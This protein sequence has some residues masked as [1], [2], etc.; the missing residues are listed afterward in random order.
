MPPAQV[1]SQAYIDLTQQ[2]TLTPLIKDQDNN[3]M[4]WEQF[5]QQFQAT[6]EWTNLS[7][8]LA[9]S[10][11]AVG[12][13]N[14]TGSLKFHS[15]EVGSIYNL[16]FVVRFTDPINGIGFLSGFFDIEITAE[17]SPFVLF[18]VSFSLVIDAYTPE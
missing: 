17:V 5:S 7:S 14:S 1:E 2:V 6:I 3:E 18:A 15:P 4:L 9:A 13:V 10:P 8:V 12:I 16:D 11:T